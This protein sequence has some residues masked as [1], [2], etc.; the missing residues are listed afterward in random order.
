VPG[1]RLGLHHNGSGPI[2]QGPAQ[3]IRLHGEPTLRV[4]QSRSVIEARPEP[5]RGKFARDRGRAIHLCGAHREVRGLRGHHRG[6]AHRLKAR[7]L[8]RA[9]AELAM[10]RAGM[11]RHQ[12]VALGGRRGEKLQVLTAEPRIVQRG[13]YGG[14]AHGCVGVQHLAGRRHGV[15]PGCNPIPAQRALT[16]AGLA[17]ADIAEEIFH[18]IVRHRL[19]RKKHAGTRDE[20]I[21]QGRHG[22]S[23]P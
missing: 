5:A 12:V 19:A 23:G 16:D 3:E 15:V 2:G 14:R 20:G 9:A 10:H 13:G 22:T 17:S 11:P 18:A 1:P 6:C 4:D 21:A 8:E 7:Q